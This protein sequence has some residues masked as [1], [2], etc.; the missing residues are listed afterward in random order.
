MASERRTELIPG[1]IGTVEAR[2]RQDPPVTA[3]RV[4]DPKRSVLRN[5]DEEKW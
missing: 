1:R 5:A 4:T 3:D 2:L